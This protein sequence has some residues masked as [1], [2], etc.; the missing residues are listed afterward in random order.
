MSKEKVF[1]IEGPEM[2]FNVDPDNEESREG[3]IELLSDV[4]GISYKWFKEETGREHW[5]MYDS[6]A[7]EVIEQCGL[8]ILHYINECGIDP[9][10]PLNGTSCKSMFMGDDLDGVSFEHFITPDVTTMAYMF[11]DAT[12]V[13]SEAVKS[14]ST[15]KVTTMAYMFAESDVDYLDLSHFATENLENVE[16]MF[17][18]CELL[19]EVKMIG[20]DF[21][22]VADFTGM[23]SGCTELSG[24]YSS[25]NWNVSTDAGGFDMFLDCFSLPNFDDDEIELEKAIFEDEGGYLSFS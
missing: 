14:F 20:W 6:R 13:T 5:V 8:K 9:I 1:V 23:F 4:E 7:F 2:V 17:D 3:A 12:G 15:D 22:K 10:M 11:A 25:E 21:S 16:S 18:S 19:E 24:I